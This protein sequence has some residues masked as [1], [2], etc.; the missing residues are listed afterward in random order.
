MRV[1]N[2]ELHRVRIPF[3]RRFDHATAA[4]DGAERIYVTLKGESGHIGF[5]E[6]MPRPYLTGETLDNVF[7]K[8]GPARASGLVGRRFADQ[9][10]LVAHLREAL[11]HAGRNLALAG[12]FEAALINLA[13]HDLGGF[14]YDALLGPKRTTPVGRCVTIGLVDDR[15]TLRR[16]ALEAKMAKATVVKVKVGGSADVERIGTL[17]SFLGDLPI[18]LDANGALSFDA[19]SDLLAG[20][21]GGAIGSIEQPLD[22]AEPDLA[23]KLKTLFETHGVPIMADESVCSAAD[24]E[25]WGG[26]GG[27]Q[28]VNVRAG[29]CGG[30]IGARLVIE[31]AR[32]HRLD[33]VGGTLVGESGV[34]DRQGGILLSRTADMPYMEGLGQARWLLE[35]D[36]TVDQSIV[37]NNFDGLNCFQWNIGQLE[38]WKVDGPL[39][40]S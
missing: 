16:Y 40:F 11:A 20:L 6:I 19:A 5:G 36:P 37:N 4:R 27:Y 24:V 10:D 28:L 17:R 12:G 32:R 9:A 23:E 2:A 31:A 1:V 8:T 18:R 33:L 25:A 22:A 30:L 21:E 3:K 7:E 29:K 39:Y 34:L 14:D 15:K 35:E 13:E 26:Q 38:R